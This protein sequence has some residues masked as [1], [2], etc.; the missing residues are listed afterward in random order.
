M[1]IC[2]FADGE[3]PAKEAMFGYLSI[4]GMLVVFIEAGL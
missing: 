1:G 3:N 2:T 4:T